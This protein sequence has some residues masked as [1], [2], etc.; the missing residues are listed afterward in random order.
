L[1]SRRLRERQAAATREHLGI[2]ARQ[3]FTEQ[4]NAATSIED[5]V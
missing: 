3:R 5:I 4:C 2:V 1:L